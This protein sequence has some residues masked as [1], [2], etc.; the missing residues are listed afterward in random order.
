MFG[1]R[2]RHP[3]GRAALLQRLR[4]APGALQPVHRRARDLRVAPAER[5]ARRSIFEDGRQRRDF[6]SVHDVARACRLALETRRR[7]RA[8]VQHRQRPQRHGRARSPSGSPRVLGTRAS[9]PRSPASTASATSATAS[10]TSRSPRELLGY[11]AGGRRSRT[12]MAELAEWLEGAGRGRPRRRR[13]PRELAARG[14]VTA[15][16]PRARV[17]H[18]LDHRRRR[19]HRHEPRRTGCSAT[20]GAVVVLDNLVAARRRAA[21][22]AGCASTH[23]RPR[24]ASR[25]PTSATALARARARSRGADA[26]LPPR[27]AGRGDDEPRRSASTTSTSTPR[28]R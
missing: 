9:S 18:A 2:L 27:R 15:M 11:R 22:C 1:A 10:P 19:L 6:V 12:G 25:S 17:D 21:T 13:R 20:G 8:R 26:R 7:R 28:A 14:L 5:Q 16:T 24:R 3:D 23:R 4:P